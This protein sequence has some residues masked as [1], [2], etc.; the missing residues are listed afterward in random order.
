MMLSKRNMTDIGPIGPT[1]KVG[2]SRE[3][4]RTEGQKSINSKKKLLVFRKFLEVFRLT[5]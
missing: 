3:P 2:G 4:K 1:P 5:D